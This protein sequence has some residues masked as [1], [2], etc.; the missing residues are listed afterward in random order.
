MTTYDFVVILK[1]L[2]T[3]E[4]VN[5]YYDYSVENYIDAWEKV[6]EQAKRIMSYNDNVIVKTIK[7]ID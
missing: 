3:N 4:T 7:V 2:D 5:H 1:R 6:V